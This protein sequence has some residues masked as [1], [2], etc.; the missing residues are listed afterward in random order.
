MEEGSDEVVR[1]WK[2]FQLRELPK[3]VFPP[4]CSIS[5][6]VFITESLT[7]NQELCGGNAYE[8]I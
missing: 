2:K 7:K 3:Q 1:S 8:N 5:D 6:L 4:A